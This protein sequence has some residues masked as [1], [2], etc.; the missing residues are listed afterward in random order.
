M[1]MGSA[2]E[3]LMVFGILGVV[4]LVVNVVFL[5]IIYFTKRKMDTVAKWPYAMGNVKISTT[6]YRNSGESG[7][8]YPVVH[9]SYQV[10]GQLY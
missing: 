8:Y 5:G 9:Y 6:E 4:F 7:A 2:L 10:S 1:N 3:G